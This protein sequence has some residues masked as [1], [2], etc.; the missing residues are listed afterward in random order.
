[1][2]LFR[3][4]LLDTATSMATKAEVLI[5]GGGPAGLSAA[6]SLARA[7]RSAI[8]FDSGEYRNAPTK[9]LHT[10]ITWDHHAPEELRAAARKELFE[11]RYSTVKLS[12]TAVKAVTKLQDGSFKAVDAAGTEWVG[13]KLV[14]A[15]GVRDLL[16]DIPG[17]AECWGKHM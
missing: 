9:H 10:F 11:G 4:H 7:R 17:F 1:M 5:I 6:L 14:L 12:N 3:K 2:Y 13:D 16:P 8:V 15:T